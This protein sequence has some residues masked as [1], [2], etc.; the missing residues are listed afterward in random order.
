MIRASN[1]Q[2]YFTCLCLCRRL[3]VKADGKFFDRKKQHSRTVLG[4]RSCTV[5][6][7]QPLATA[8]FFDAQ[9]TA[10]DVNN[11]GS[12]DQVQRSLFIT[13]QAGSSLSILVFAVVCSTPITLLRL[14]SIL[15][16]QTEPLYEHNHIAPCI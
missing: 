12:M 7:T 3:L 1:F 6:P 13:A 16:T 4:M 15:N 11:T 10:A 14:F 9:I 5:S 8:G 2:E